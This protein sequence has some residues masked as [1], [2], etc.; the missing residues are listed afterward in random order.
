MDAEYSASGKCLLPRVISGSTPVVYL[1]SFCQTSNL[2]AKWYLHEMNLQTGQ[3]V[4]AARYIGSDINNYVPNHSGYPTF[5]DKWHQQRPALLQV[6]NSN[7]TS[8]PN[9][10]YGGYPG[11]AITVSANCTSLPNTPCYHALIWAVLPKRHLD[12]R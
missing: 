10:A 12:E 7:N 4:V 3:D 11:G 6:K 2:L 8:T 5:T 9:L 1:T